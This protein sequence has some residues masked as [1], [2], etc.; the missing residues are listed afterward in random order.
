[1]TTVHIGTAFLIRA[2]SKKEL[3]EAYCVSVKTFNKWLAGVP[4]LGAYEGK[5]YTPKQVQKIVD[6]LGTP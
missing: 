1:M 6:H 2:C 3:R 4:D 5:T